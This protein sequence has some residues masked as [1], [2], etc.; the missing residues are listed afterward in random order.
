MDKLR[1]PDERFASLDWPYAPNYVEVDDNFGGTVRIH[2]V[3]EGPGDGEGMLCMHGQPSWCYLYKK[4]IPV[5]TAAGFRVIAP[6]LVGKKGRD[7]KPRGGRKATA[8]ATTE[9]P[10]EGDER[11]GSCDGLGG[12][13]S[14]TTRRK[15]SIP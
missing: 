8:H 12:G 11:L 2:Y 9:I 3:D 1:T 5:L 14:S 6:D 10:A 4:M 15:T 13:G 7:Q